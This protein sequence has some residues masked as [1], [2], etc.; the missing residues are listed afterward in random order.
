MPAWLLRVMCLLATA[1]ILS[2]QSG[3]SAIAGLVRDPSGS[4]V[5]GVHV[6]ASSP[7]L[8]EGRRTAETDS[9]GQ[10][11]IVDLRSGDYTVTFTHVGFRTLK[12]EGITLPASF[13]AMV[14]ADLALGQT[15]DAITVSAETPLVDVQNSLAQQVIDR[16][17]LDQIPTGR[18]PF[19]VGQLIAGVT[20]SNP[21]VGGTGGM[22][23]PTL[24]VH[25]S[26]GND[27]VI[28]VDGI[29]IQ[30][31]A[32]SGNQTGF[33]YNDGLMQE[34]GYLTNTLPAEAPVGGIQISMVPRE[35]GNQFHGSIFGTGANSSL[36]S[37]NSNAQLV[38]LGLKARNRI[39][40]VYDLNATLGGPIIKDRI[41]FFTSFRRWGANNFLANTFFPNGDRAFDDNRLTDLTLRLTFQVTKNNKLSVSYDRGFKFRGHRPNNYI[42]VNFSDPL[43]DVVQ[44]S[45]LNYM[46]QAKWTSTI[47]NRLLVEAG[48]TRLPVN[49]DLGFEPGVQPGAIAVWDIGAS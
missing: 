42:G 14:N 44:K 20:T 17:K 26:S 33:Y 49:Y 37:D 35:G 7:A 43:A 45:W 16:T 2:A 39:D 23:Q 31:V 48:Y 25:G 10:Y 24:Q 47:T 4:I 29:Q 21:D 18:D 19:A 36:Q 38:A 28:V 13:T 40:T 30:H 8:I 41:W 22:Q 5:P 3:G 1:A 12:H 46:L 32:F 15:A 27:N 6:E 34:I 11:R 9:N